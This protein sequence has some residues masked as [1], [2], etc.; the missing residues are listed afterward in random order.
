MVIIYIYIYYNKIIFTQ[1]QTIAIEF[2]LL[3][4]K[5]MTEVFAK[6]IYKNIKYYSFESLNNIP[7]Y[8]L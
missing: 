6:P 4:I 8:S 2:L 5:L 1:N 7:Y 3:I